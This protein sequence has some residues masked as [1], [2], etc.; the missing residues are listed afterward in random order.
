MVC[1]NV[2]EGLCKESLIDEAV[3][4]FSKT[5]GNGCLPNAAS[6]ETVIRALL[7]RD[8]NEQALKLLS[9]MISKGLLMNN[10]KED[11]KFMTPSEVE[12]ILE[13]EPCSSNQTR[14][15]K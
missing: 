4:L 1:A 12:H 11:S 9:E 7:A 2:E 14:S 5:K 15:V 3:T 6:Y 13:W 8:E 10:S